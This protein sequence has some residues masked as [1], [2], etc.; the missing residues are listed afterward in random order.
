MT[1]T[2]EG[3]R[4][5][6]WPP[7]SN[8]ARWLRLGTAAVLLVSHLLVIVGIIGVGLAGFP[9]LHPRGGWT[10]MA[11]SSF[12]L[13]VLLGALFLFQGPMR[14][15][16]LGTATAW[17]ALRISGTVTSLIGESMDWPAWVGLAELVILGGLVGYQMVADVRQLVHRHRDTSWRRALFPAGSFRVVVLLTVPTILLVGAYAWGKL[18]RRQY[19]LA[20]ELSAF[21]RLAVS[22]QEEAVLG[23]LERK[24]EALQR[25]SYRD[26]TV[27]RAAAA[28]GNVRLIK[29]LIVKG[30]V[31]DAP[32]D[33]GLTPLD[34]AAILGHAEA[35]DVLRKAGAEADLL[36]ATAIGDRE[37]VLELLEE[38]GLPPHPGPAGYT[39]LHMALRFGHDRIARALVEQGAPVNAAA[40]GS[41]KTTPWLEELND[42]DRN[43]ISAL[44]ATGAVTPLHEAVGAGSPEM[45]ELLIER[46]VRVNARDEA[47]LTP[48]HWV[49]ILGRAEAVERLLVVGAE[50][51]LLDAS[52]RGTVERALLKGRDRIADILRG[53]S[54]IGKSAR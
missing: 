16:R 18:R 17:L 43:R 41:L 3:A 48:L 42:E 38:E 35:A 47:G 21:H 7:E 26:A 30:T 45:I 29:A 19:G 32:D 24:P 31:I 11:L 39:P 10:Q 52:G 28:G 54:L 50:V 37:A 49:V 22:G 25:R 13:G 27:L 33:A 36:S 14:L 9:L 6:A 51:E 5:P 40:R 44:F 20:R 15:P 46:G 8:V 4:E 2:V 1:E 23:F 12:G 53:Y 34:W